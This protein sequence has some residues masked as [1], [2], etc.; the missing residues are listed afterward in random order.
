[1]DE[2]EDTQEEENVDEEEDALDD[3]GFGINESGK[4]RICQVHVSK[5]R[6]THDSISPRFRDGR[7]LRRL[8]DDLMVGKAHPLRTASLQLRGFRIGN[9]L[10]SLS[11]RRLF[12]LREYQRLVQQP[13]VV[14]VRIEYETS[15]SQWKGIKKFHNA[16][17]TRH[18]GFDVAV[19]PSRRRSRSRRGGRT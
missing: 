2:S 10:Y 7:P 9:E 5:V 3:G 16:K 4:P 18:C 17:T 8:I 14:S 6:F 15:K 11:N 19:R 1:M 13:V 12:C